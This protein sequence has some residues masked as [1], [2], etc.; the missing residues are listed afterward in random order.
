MA[1]RSILNVLVGGTRG[2]RLWFGAWFGFLYAAFGVP[3]CIWR[4]WPPLVY[5]LFIF[6]G[7]LLWARCG[8]LLV[9]EGYRER[10][11]LAWLLHPDKSLK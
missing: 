1:K 6:P 5:F 9:S 11:P 3:F 7:V 2:E 10:P 8:N 4:G